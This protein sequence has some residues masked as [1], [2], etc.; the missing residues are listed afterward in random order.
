MADELHPDRKLARHRGALLAG[1][2]ARPTAAVTTTAGTTTRRQ[3]SRQPR[4]RAPSSWSARGSR[5]VQPAKGM[6]APA[7]PASGLPCRSGSGANRLS[8]SPCSPWTS[9]SVQESDG[10]DEARDGDG[11]HRG[12]RRVAR[13]C[14]HRSARVGVRAPRSSSRPWTGCRSP[15]SSP[16][17]SSSRRAGAGRTDPRTKGAV[18]QR[19][20]GHELAHAGRRRHAAPSRA[21]RR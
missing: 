12:G 7:A 14:R 15:A 16:F 10:A 9:A 19:A 5:P 18:T 3:P 2:P 1:S 11:E 4:R 8:A 17:P 20:A 13:F 21:L 6:A